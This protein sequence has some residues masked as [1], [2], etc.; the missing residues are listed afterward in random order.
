MTYSIA[1]AVLGFGLVA[2]VLLLVRAIASRSWVLMWVAAF[3]SLAAS[4]ITVFSIGP[5]I[6]LS[7]CLLIAGSW[8]LR[9]HA[10]G[11]QWALAIIA[12]LLVWF[13]V[14]PT[15]LAEP[16]WLPGFGIM[17][18]VG[19]VGLLIPLV[20]PSESPESRRNN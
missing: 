6:Y 5:V 4:A 13:I 9:R 10:V 17:I 14:V 16:S 15:Q 12:A 1:V 11:R 20:P 2:T 8:A 18:V 7:T 3:A 19:L